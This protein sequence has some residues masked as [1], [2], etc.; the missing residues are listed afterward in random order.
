MQ[1]GLLRDKITFFEITNVQSR[2]GAMTKTKTQVL[3]TLCY[4]KK[5]NTSGMGVDAMQEFI[6]GTIMVQVRNNK[7]INDKQRFHYG[8]YDYR[9]TLIDEQR[10]NT[11]LIT[12]TRLNDNEK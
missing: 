11:L 5:L 1:A 2:S 9:I 7:K 3:S 6:A 4:R 12:G 8:I 10:D